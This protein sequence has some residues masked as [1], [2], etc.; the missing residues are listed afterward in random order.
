MLFAAAMPAAGARKYGFDNAGGP[1][2]RPGRGGAGAPV[3]ARRGGR[4]RA[5]RHSAGHGRAD[6]LWRCGGQLFPAPWFQPF[7]VGAGAPGGGA[8]GATQSLAAQRIVPPLAD[9]H[10]RHPDHAPV[11]GRLHH[12]RHPTALAAGAAGGLAHHF[13]YRPALHAAA[14]GG[15]DHRPGPAAGD[16]RVDGGAGAV[17]PVPGLEPG[18]AAVGGP[19]GAP[20]AGRHR[21]PDGAAHGAADAVLHAAVAGHGAAPRRTPGDRHRAAGRRCAAAY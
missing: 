12:L 1:G 20:G 6:R 15:G 9:L 14:A 13:Y 10:R 7:A 21:L 8:G 11:A 2:G 3:R 19:P 4:R 17:E 16:P 5:A 18:G